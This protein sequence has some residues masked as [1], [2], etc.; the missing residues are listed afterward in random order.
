[1]C[2]W[3]RIKTRP[4]APDGAGRGLGRAF[5]FVIVG[6]IGAALGSLWDIMVCAGSG[7]GRKGACSGKKRAL[8]LDILA[9]RTHL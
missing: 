4:S 5:L 3:T 2:G 1:M 6:A 9:Y 7:Y 8:M